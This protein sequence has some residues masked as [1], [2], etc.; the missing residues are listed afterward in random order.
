MMCGAL[1]IASFA[2]SQVVITEVMYDDTASTDVEWVEIHNTTG[3]AIDISGWALSDAVHPDTLG[4]EGRLVVPAGTSIAGGAYLVLCKVALP[5]IEGEVVC[6]TA[7]SWTLGNSGDNLVLYTAVTG[8]TLVDGSRSVQYPDLAGT[9]L[10]N[11][12]EKCD[13]NAGWSGAP[14]DWH[15]SINVF[16]TSGRYRHCTPGF[17][18]SP[19]GDVTPP[20]ISSVSAISAFQLDVLFN[21]AV[22]QATSEVEANYSV[23]NGIGNPQTALR[24]GTNIALVHLTYANAIPNNNYT[25]TINAVQDTSGNPISNGTFDFVVN[26]S[27]QTGDVVINEIMYDDTAGGDI[28]WVELYNVTDEPINISNWILTD[29]PQYPPTIEGAVQIPPST[30][31]GAHAYVVVAWQELP[32]ITGEIVANPY[33]GGG[34]GLNNG[35]DNIAL[36]TDTTNGSLIDGALNS[37]YPDLVPNNAG[38]SIE[39]CVESDPWSPDVSAWHASTNDFSATGRYRRCTPGAANSICVPDNTPPTLVSATVSSETNLDV[40]FSETLDLATANAAG[41][42]SVDNGMGTP[43][44]AALQPDLMTVRLTFAL[45]FSPNTYLLTV[46]NVADIALNPIL[47]NSQIQFVFTP[48]PEDLRF[49]EFMPNPNFTG[50]GDSLG[51]WFEVY[52]AGPDPVDLAGWILQDNAGRDTIEAATINSSQYFVFCSNGDSATNGGVPEN[53]AYH[54]GTSGW[55]ISLNNSGETLILRNPAGFQVSS[56]NYSGL[57][58]A[59]GY[60]A[61]LSDLNADPTDPA[62]WC[63]PTVIWDGA[64]NGDHGTPGAANICPTPVA[65]DTLTLCQLREEDVCGIPTQLGNRV[66]SR[67]V[68]TRVDTCRPIAYFESDQC[69]VAIF[70][71]AVMDT[72]V[73]HTRPMAVGDSIQVDGYLTQFRGLTEFSTLANLVPIVT[74]LGVRPVP[75]EVVIPCLDISN[76]GTACAGEQWE[77]RHVQ[78]QNVVFANQGGTFSYGDSNYV[79]LCGGQDTI[80]FRVDSCDATLGATIPTGPVTINAIATQYDTASCYCNNYQLVYGG[81]E[82]FV[83]SPCVQPTGLTVYRTIGVETETIELRWQPGPAQPCTC[84]KIYYTTNATGVFPGDYTLLTCVCN[85]THYTD[86]VPIST[87]PKRFYLVTADTGCE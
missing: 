64:N 32:E 82:T 85:Q 41:N 35:G 80:Y 40:L 39:K 33:F 79:A 4:G 83:S 71:A 9:N 70:G 63:Q 56:R 42:Y 25:I 18:N 21:E 48:P 67:G 78:V 81:G 66:V 15:E 31:L 51:E 29:A 8:G 19:C 30:T 47:P 74:Y 37:N 72:M 11:T 24:D 12:I 13:P 77:S 45:A 87:T 86:V 62:N 6:A 68:V 7:G 55:G 57:P 16:A 60:S 46:N 50:T 2:Y 58:F 5:E 10:G 28:E 73:G 20:T 38:Y 65:P 75:D 36:F 14:A 44:G 61:Q 84:F 3:S 27:T 54:F 59:A 53:Y 43:T 34:L 1:L 17:A 23:N 22:D 49:T 76:Y 69:A 26:I 52:N